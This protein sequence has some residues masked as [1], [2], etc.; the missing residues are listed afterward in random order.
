[1]PLSDKA[2]T[3]EATDGLTTRAQILVQGGLVEDLRVRSAVPAVGDSDEMETEPDT[4]DESR[5]SAA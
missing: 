5:S 1:M 3:A 4:D 2:D